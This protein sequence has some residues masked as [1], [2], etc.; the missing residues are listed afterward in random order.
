MADFGTPETW[1]MKGGQFIEEKEFILPEKK[2]Q[3]IESKDEK[4]D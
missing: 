2:P 4:K 1:N 3:E